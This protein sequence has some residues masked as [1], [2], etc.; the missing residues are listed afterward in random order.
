MFSTIARQRFGS[1]FLLLRYVWR[2]FVF[3]VSRS[4]FSLSVKLLFLHL[5]WYLNWGMCCPLSRIFYWSSNL[6]WPHFSPT[7]Q[8]AKIF[9]ASAN[10]WF[11][12]FF[13]PR[14]NLCSHIKKSL[15]S[16]NPL[17]QERRSLFSLVFWLARNFPK[18]Q[19]LSEKNLV[20]QSTSKKTCEQ[21]VSR[22]DKKTLIFPFKIP[23]HPPS[24]MRI[25]YTVQT[26]HLAWLSAS[27]KTLPQR[28]GAF[29]ARPAARPTR[30]DIRHLG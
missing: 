12:W 29:F 17:S 24:P 28:L 14:E 13:F 5:W 18:R 25:Y 20:L 7:R 30:Y 11:I 27:N 22:N 3:F 19:S 4:I 15:I 21:A 16:Y 2:C 23:K 9:F 26:K 1:F 10:L 6:N 8:I